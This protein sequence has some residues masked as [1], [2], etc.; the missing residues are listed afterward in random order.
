MEEKEL[1]ALLSE[2]SKHDNYTDMY[3][4]D[5]IDNEE[6]PIKTLEDYKKLFSKLAILG[7]KIEMDFQDTLLSTMTPV[8]YSVTSINDKNENVLDF[9]IFNNGEV[10]LFEDFFANSNL[11]GYDISKLDLELQ[12]SSLLDKL[13]DVDVIKHTMNSIHR[14]GK[15]LERNF[16][17]YYSEGSYNHSKENEN[18]ILETFWCAHKLLTSYDVN[19]AHRTDNLIF[20]IEVQSSILYNLCSFNRKQCNIYDVKTLK[21]IMNSFFKIFDSDEIEDCD[22]QELST[23][24]IK[25]VKSARHVSRERKKKL[26]E[27]P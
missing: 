9:G 11:S 24:L 27:A 1:R 20:D 26:R 12:N 22:K 5:I 4:K 10:I 21:S 13:C 6:N 23:K 17:Y 25:A 14:L 7:I 19:F 16:N 8:L 15:I 18:N 2:L 3:I